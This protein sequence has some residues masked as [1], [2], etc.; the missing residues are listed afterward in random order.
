MSKTLLPRE[1]VSLIHHIELN[2]SGWWDKSLQRIILTAVWLL[3]DWVSFESI[4]GYMRD[5]MNIPVD[6]NRIL[7]QIE[8]LRKSK[9]ILY[10]CNQY[11]I[12][13]SAIPDLEMSVSKI[14]KIE[15]EAKSKFLV[16]LGVDCSSYANEE[17]WNAFNENLLHP[18]IHE[19]GVR[20]YKLLSIGG[21]DFKASTWLTEF[22]KRF[23]VECRQHLHAAL[24]DFF[25]PKDKRVRSYVLCLLSSYFFIEASGLSSETINKLNISSD[26]K[27]I[28][29]IYLDTNFVFS[30][31]ALHENPSNEAAISLVNLLNQLSNH[32]EIKLFIL[33]PTIYESIRVLN[34]AKNE[35]AGLRLTQNM[36]EAA[37]ET[38][39][40]V[41]GVAQKFF[42]ESSK[43]ENSISAEEYFSP[44]VN[45]FKTILKSKGVE[46]FDQNVDNYR[47]YQRVIDD[48]LLQQAYEKKRYNERAK[49][50]ESLTHDVVLWHFIHDKRSP[51]FDSPVD[52]NY[53]VVT[54]DKRFIK[55]DDYKQHN[56]TNSVPICLHPSTLIQML[57]FW[58]PRTEQFE[59]AMLSSMRLPFLFQEFDIESETVTVNILKA[60]SRFEN[61]GDLP[62]QAIASILVNNA[63]RNKFASEKDP[64]IQT[65]LVKEAI[66]DEY[67]K[68]KNELSIEKDNL[69]SFKKKA[70][71]S[72]GEIEGLKNENQKGESTVQDYKQKLVDANERIRVLEDKV[73]SF[74]DN[75]SER[76]KQKA[77][78]WE[79]TFFAGKWILWF[80]IIQFLSTTILTNYY[81]SISTKL[82]IMQTAPRLV[83]YL[84][85]LIS[86]AFIWIIDRYGVKKPNIMNW[87]A[88][89]KFH[90]FKN[91]LFG[92]VISGILINA[93]YDIIKT[94]H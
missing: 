31:L 58:V 52:A 7:E 56:V 18:M 35:L 16:L 27:P 73:K 74:I 80:C 68:I 1:L 93:A 82:L 38:R 20:V 48:I 14:E 40:E 61:I 19:M 84:F 69:A 94:F 90:K 57:Q 5:D 50:Y 75:D 36:A 46:L 67:N 41:R 33:A 76:Q 42:V 81:D 92:V 22:L 26:H 62:K 59:E 86:I 28:F 30:I 2:K 32:I 63:F 72:S 51:H 43:L 23:P 55:F 44:F 47:M 12:A 29:N 39:Y 34:S 79:R 89:K 45:N 64:Y 54:I 10:L 9:H 71:D 91:M 49:S 88:F 53:W 87:G 8:A 4:A 37:L 65:Q 25:D 13:E 6:N 83:V 24:I 70:E 66:I 11:K 3:G 21:D 85:A 60:L 77:C 17:T 15:S 78:K